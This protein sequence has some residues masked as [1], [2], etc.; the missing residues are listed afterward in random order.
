M[1][2]HEKL[3]ET[4]RNYEK[5]GEKLREAKFNQ[6]KSWETMREIQPWETMRNHEVKYNQY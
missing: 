4:E 2:N 6:E 1:K 3:R 5:P